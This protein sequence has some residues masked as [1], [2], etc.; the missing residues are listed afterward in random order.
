M[1]NHSNEGSDLSLLFKYGFQFFMHIL[2]DDQEV[3]TQTICSFL[4]V[5]YDFV[6]IALKSRKNIISYYIERMNVT[7]YIGTL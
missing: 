1:S 3:Y 4:K 6:Y 5:K 2:L 7:I